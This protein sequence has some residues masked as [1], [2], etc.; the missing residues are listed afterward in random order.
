MILKNILYS[1]YLSFLLLAASCSSS[2]KGLESMAME[3]L[4]DALEKAMEDQ[5]SVK[6]GA[7]IQ[8]PETIFDCDSL[9]IIHFQAVAKD[10]SGN[11]YSFPVRYV[12]LRDVF[13]SAA[14]GHPVYSEMVAGS[15]TMDRGEVE[16]LKEYCREHSDELYVYYAGAASPI[17]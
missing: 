10:P 14:E 4:P 3:R 1:F 13:M 6:G 12:F 2:P 17:P 16:K 9:C 5:M 7:R 11:E 15:P 8:S